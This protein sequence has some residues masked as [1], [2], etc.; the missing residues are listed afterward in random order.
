MQFC[1]LRH[2]CAKNYQS[3]LKFDKVIMKTILSVFWRQGKE[4]DLKQLLYAHVSK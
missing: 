2:V 1:R 4:L 3:W